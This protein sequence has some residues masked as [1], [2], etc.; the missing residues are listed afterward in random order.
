ML[1]EVVTEIIYVYKRVCVLLSLSNVPAKNSCSL[2]Y[3]SSN[4]SS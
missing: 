2:A 1:K 3:T 4:L